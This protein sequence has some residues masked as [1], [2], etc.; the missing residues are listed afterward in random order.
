MTVTA[1]VGADQADPTPANNSLTVT[2][3]VTAIGRTI[4]VTNTSDSGPGSLRQA[5]LDS[6]ADAGDVD[7]IS[8]NIPGTGVRT[9]APL[10][11]LPA[12]TQPV[13][14]RRHD[15]A[16]IRGYADHR[17]E[18]RQRPDLVAR[19][20]AFN[21]S[22]REQR[23]GSGRQSVPRCRYHCVR[24]RHHDSQRQ[25]HRHDR[26]AAPSRLANCYGSRCSIR[27]TTSSAASLPASGNLI[28]GNTS[29]GIV[30]S[31]FSSGRVHQVI[32]GNTIGTDVDRD[33]AGAERD[34]DR[35]RNG[36]SKPDRW[37][38]GGAPQPDIRQH[39]DRAS[40]SK[41]EA[42]ATRSSATASRPTAR[43]AS[44]STATA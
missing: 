10:T 30:I 37:H 33:A 26:Q 17:A 5:I 11:G 44:I 12:I 16:W 25:L 1:G 24:T 28:S 35:S 40:S 23:Q 31:G 15:A 7:R 27:P 38:D 42:P 8:F 19:A 29:V 22:W 4:L 41:A 34:R 21:S 36:A 18:R 13:D 14:H 43:S 3:T 32:V 9:I 2:T 39:A 20:S 6:N